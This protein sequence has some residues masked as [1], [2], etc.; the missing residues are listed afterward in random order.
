MFLRPAQSG[1]LS[2]LWEGGVQLRPKSGLHSEGRAVQCH[3]EAF[4]YTPHPPALSKTHLVLQKSDQ[5]R[6]VRYIPFRTKT[7]E[8]NFCHVLKINRCVCWYQ[9]AVINV[10]F[11]KFANFS[12]QCLEGELGRLMWFQTKPLGPSPTVVKDMSPQGPR[13][14]PVFLPACCPLLER[15]SESTVGDRNSLVQPS[16]VGRSESDEA[17]T[18]VWHSWA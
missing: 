5:V 17:D 14:I 1:I 15:Q 13:V 9:V 10:A 16:P 4:F 3:S 2:T 8:G 6:A 12:L 18:V 11:H 7:L